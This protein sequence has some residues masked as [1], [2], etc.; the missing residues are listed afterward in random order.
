MQVRGLSEQEFKHQT[1]LDYLTRWGL[2]KKQAEMASD[3]EWL[4]RCEVEAD[5][6]LNKKHKPKTASKTKAKTYGFG[7]S[8]IKLSEK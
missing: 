2:T 4:I 7:T 8:P 5:P 3:A 6:K 1:M